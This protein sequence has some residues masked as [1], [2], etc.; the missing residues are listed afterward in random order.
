MRI[1]KT[2]DWDA[3]IR[4]VYDLEK[5]IHKASGHVLTKIAEEAQYTVLDTIKAQRLGWAPL[6]PMWR[7]IK[8]SRG[9]SRLIYVAT[10]MMY[11]SIDKGYSK[12][13][14]FVGIPKG[15][16]KGNTTLGRIAQKLEYGDLAQR[17]PARPLWRP[18][19]KIVRKKVIQTKYIYYDII[20]KH[21]T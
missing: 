18:V 11:R 17:L 3:A 12:G 19:A 8:K 9:W 13:A 15:I 2:G 7:A 6:S 1:K 21:L 20:K 4:R 5:N 10:G 14:S 16:K